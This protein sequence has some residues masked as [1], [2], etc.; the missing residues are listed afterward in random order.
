MRNIKLTLEYDG[1]DFCGW[2]W[3][4]KGRTV[5]GTLQSSLKKLLQESP[6]VIAAGRTDAGVHALGQV[7]NF[8]TKSIL[9][10]N[11]IRLGL[12]SFLPRDVTILEAE[13]EDEKFNARFDAVKRMYRYVIT[14]R[15][16]AVG[17]QY[18]WYCKFNLDLDKIKNASEFLIGEHVFSAFSRADDEETHY[19]CNVESVQWQETKD[20]IILEICANR[21]LH[22]MVR[23]IIG[24]MVEVGRGRLAPEEIKEILKTRDRNRIG[25]TVPPQGLFLIKVYY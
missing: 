17:R 21:F 4:P 13:E 5:Q 23:I 9:D 6:T 19:L 12:N 3:Q 15:P 14:K 1:T 25:F 24:T 11:S 10:L 18:S 7:V 20:E 22:N 2:Q 8:K 16:R